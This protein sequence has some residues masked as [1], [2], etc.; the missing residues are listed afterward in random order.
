MDIADLQVFKAVADEGGIVKAAQRLHR[1]PSNVTTRVKQL[2]VSL[3][4]ELFHRERRRLHLSAT[5]EL[6]LGYAERLLQLVEE[7]RGVVSGAAPRGV[8]RLG[9]LESTAASRLVPVLAEFHRRYPEVRLELTTGTNDALVAGVLERRLDAAFAAEPPPSRLLDHMPAFSERL[10]I[11]SSAD[12]V[13][14]AR[15]RD[16]RGMSIIAFPNGCAYRRVLQRWL[17][18]RN[19][20]TTPILEL[21]SYHAIVACVASGTGIALVPESVLDTMPCARVQR[22]EI[23]KAYATITTPLIWRTRELSL[24]VIALRALVAEQK[25]PHGTGRARPSAGQATSGL[26]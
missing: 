10:V 13:P 21:N 12:H 26:R 15:A 19:V 14:I 20:A 9:T 1:V 6:L 16:A 4:V 22:H 2:E 3:G 5:G 17:G 7:A 18:R 11:I 24:P 23:T 8:L 25:R